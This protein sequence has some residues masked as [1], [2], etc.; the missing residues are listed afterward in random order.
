[1]PGVFLFL[2]P[3]LPFDHNRDSEE[4]Q[5]LGKRFS[6]ETKSIKTLSFK[7]M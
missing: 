1:M 3:T 7:H 5:H 6:N 4:N 2:C